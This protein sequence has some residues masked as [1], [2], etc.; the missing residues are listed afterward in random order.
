LETRIP[1]WY[2]VLLE[3]E[4]NGHGRTLGTIGSRIVAEVVEGALRH[5]PDSIVQQL[6]CN[7][8]WR[9]APW[10]TSKGPTPVDQ[11]YDL[12][13]VVGLAEPVAKSA[14][15]DSDQFSRKD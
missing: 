4:V 5:D 6:R 12:A 8:D 10:A 13:V 15:R 2:Y 11:L 9:P 3:A 1:L 14:E 7:L